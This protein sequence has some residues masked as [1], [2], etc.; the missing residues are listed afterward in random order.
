MLAN[1]RNTLKDTEHLIELYRH[2]KDGQQLPGDYSDLLRMSLVFS[3]SA[4]DKLIH[5]VIVHEMVEIYIGRR[6]PTPKYLSERLS[7]DEHQQLTGETE[8]PKEILF[9]KIVRNKF[10]HISFM[11]P[12]K[13]ADGLAMVWNENDR[14]AAIAS[15]MMLERQMAAR[16]LRNIFKRRNAI[17]HEADIEIS[18]NTKLPLSTE[19]AHRSSQYIK[20]LGETIHSLVVTGDN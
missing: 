2:C 6:V 15:E 13:L 8:E 4:L 17:V 12:K 14:W 5:D 11:D 20:I 16:E 9:E 18:S 10:A 1:F 7:F 3:M 19:D